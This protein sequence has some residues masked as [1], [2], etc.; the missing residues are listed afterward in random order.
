MKSLRL[1][2]MGVALAT[3]GGM[4][5]GQ[6][7]PT[8]PPAPS[9]PAATPNAT[10]PAPAVRRGPPAPTAL[11]DGP[12][13]LSTQ[14]GPV[15][16]TL[17][18]KGLD[19]PWAMAFLPNGDMLVTERPGRLRIIRKGVL[20]PTPIAG[21]PDVL[22]TG[23][24]GLMDI[25]LHPKFAK[26]RLI[27]M[28][29]SKPGAQTRD[30]STLAVVRARWDGGA[31]LTDVQDIF[32]ADAWYGAAPLPQRCCGQGPSSGSYGG[33]L[34]FDRKGYLYV[35]SGDRNYGEKVQD[36]SN[37]FGKILR[38]R[39]DGSVPPDNPFIG[40]PGYKPEIYTIGHRNPLGLTIHPVTG[41]LWSSEF[42]PRGGDEVNE[43]KR[44]HNYG[45]I[46]VTQGA[47][48]NGEPAK[49]VK[50]VPGMDDPVLTWAPSINPGNLLFYNGKTF[51]AWRGNMLMPT[52][53]RSVVRETF[54][55][56]GKPVAQELMLTE[57]KQRFRDIR[58]GPDGYLYLLTDETK[59]AVLRIEPGKK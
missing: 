32:V 48:Y 16:V 40:K 6:G 3:Y 47:H 14:T 58:V 31:T 21:V 23:I 17:V 29:Y 55:A 7:A 28:A 1:L 25:A 11:G 37:H 20:D 51:P 43:I 41:A 54:D 59:G 39:D 36:P 13:D 8:A 57:L 27:Y 33:R 18:T 10:A 46:D 24:G 12:W 4:A 38:L 35:T 50:G 30:Q 53:M 42:G 49:A 56:A 22:A 19:H 44:G 5:A 2:A 26:N 45:W 34:A 52:M 9:A 15:H